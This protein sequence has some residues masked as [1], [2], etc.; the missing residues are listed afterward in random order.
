MHIN[1][2][3]F[4]SHGPSGSVHSSLISLQDEPGVRKQSSAVQSIGHCVWGVYLTH[5]T[6]SWIVQLPVQL[7]AKES[8]AVSGGSMKTRPNPQILMLQVRSV[9]VSTEG[10]PCCHKLLCGSTSL[11]PVPV[12][13]AAL[14]AAVVA[15]QLG[16]KAAELEAHV[17]AVRG[18]HHHACAP[19]CTG[20]R[21]DS[22][23]H[24]VRWVGER[25]AAMLG[26]RW[27]DEDSGG[28]AACAPP[29]ASACAVSCARRTHV[30]RRRP[31]CPRMHG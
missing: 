1:P 2:V 7:I 26:A 15:A 9:V 21:E 19:V 4:A 14:G 29:S 8:T 22:R 27:R 12:G 31:R 18:V 13:S 24:G 28:M 10:R 11:R 23:M 5:S 17:A 20:M 6:Y 3:H 30:Q 16:A 25:Q